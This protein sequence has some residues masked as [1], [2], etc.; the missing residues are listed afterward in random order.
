MFVLAFIGIAASDVSD[1]GSQTYWSLLAIVFGLICLGARLGAR[2]ARHRLVEGR[3][4]APRC[5]GS[6]CCSRSSSSTC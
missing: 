1:R 2:A 4:H 5:T 3:A 6:A